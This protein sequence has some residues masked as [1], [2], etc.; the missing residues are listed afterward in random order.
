[1]ET[2]STETE[3]TEGAVNRRNEEAED[4]QRGPDCFLRSFSV[5]PFLLFTVSPVPSVSG[6]AGACPRFQTMNVRRNSMTGVP[7]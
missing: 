6:Y 4:E 5:S 1:M 2:E 7:D 3:N